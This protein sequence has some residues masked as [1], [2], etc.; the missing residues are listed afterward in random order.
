MIP[1]T[2]LGYMKS[3]WPVK[4]SDLRTFS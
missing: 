1:N 2:L 4:R 3:T